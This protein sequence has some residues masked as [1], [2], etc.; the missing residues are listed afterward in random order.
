M[1]SKTSDSKE[2]NSKAE[3]PNEA[4]LTEP[5]TPGEEPEFNRDKTLFYLDNVKR[6]ETRDVIKKID[7]DNKGK[8]TENEVVEYIKHESVMTKKAHFYQQ[9][10]F[11]LLL[12]IFLLII[13]VSVLIYFVVDQSAELS[14]NDATKLLGNVMNEVISE[15]NSSNFSLTSDNTDNIRKVFDTFDVNSDSS[16]DIEEFVEYWLYLKPNK[17]A[18][19]RMDVNGDQIL[20]YRE[21]VA[22]LTMVHTIPVTQPLFTDLLGVAVQQ[23][24]NYSYNA[25]HPDPIFFE[26]A[27]DLYF[28]LFD[29]DYKGYIS[30]SDYASAVSTDLFYSADSNSN[31]K[32][33]FD[34]F[35]NATFYEEAIS[36]IITM[37]NGIST[38]PSVPNGFTISLNESDVIGV[39]LHKCPNHNK[40][41]TA[42]AQ[43]IQRRLFGPAVVVNYCISSLTRIIKCWATA[44]AAVE[45]IN[46]GAGCFCD[47]I[48]TYEEIN[49]L[50]GKSIEK[51]EE[52]CDTCKLEVAQ[53]CADFVCE[54]VDCCFAENGVVY[55]IDGSSKQLKD[56]LV[57]DYVLDDD[58]HYTKVIAVERNRVIKLKMVTLYMHFTDNNGLNENSIT[59]TGDH[60]LYDNDNKLIAASKLIIGD[61]LYDNYTIYDIIETEEWP[62]TP[63]T[64]SGKIYVN[65]AKA[66][67]Y[68]GDDR[69]AAIY[70]EVLTPFRWISQNIN[71]WLAA[72]IVESCISDFL[73]IKNMIIEPYNLH[74]I[75]EG[76]SVST[77]LV[78]LLC[79]IAIYVK[80]SIFLFLSCLSYQNAILCSFCGLVPLIIKLKDN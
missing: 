53:E 17:N 54:A 3:Q 6:K 57:G 36:T 11:W 70:H 25:A 4:T 59:L 23:M 43:S 76:G 5:A 47:C 10:V 32:L 72:T 7:V 60:L 8:V 42:A 34:E 19:G 75:F 20:S 62:A 50:C 9:F 51:N 31:G 45:C 29:L 66:S 39:E 68:I 26:Y 64:M 15:Y 1:A 41:T 35:V 38:F 27:A 21:T 55:L 12:T 13:G 24:Y 46:A 69:V 44:R 37:S 65:G 16:L 52:L 78:T 74:W 58:G 49:H 67:C 2:S 63:I 22:F 71:E 80:K 30:H 14:K 56:V 79:L 40:I 73:W 77:M 18:F 28:E 33:S 61:T 48:C